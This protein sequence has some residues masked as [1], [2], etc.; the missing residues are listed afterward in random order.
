MQDIAEAVGLYKGSLYHYIVSKEDLL[1][2]A[3]ER[4]LAELLVEVERVAAD[5]SLSASDQLRR[6]VQQH[7]MS[8]A[9]N[10]DAL[11]VYLYDFRALAGESLTTV[12]AQRERYRQLVTE[13]I[14]RG[15]ERGEF[16]TADPTI[17]TLGLLGMCNWVAQWYRPGGRLRPSD[18]GELFAELILHGLGVTA[19]SQAPARRPSR[20]RSV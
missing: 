20:Q 13:V 16:T 19:S 14:T 5:S 4:A 3:F 11:T 15:V 2:K 17:A 8:V 7:V 12:V 10:L 1:V 6:I 9:G 18:I